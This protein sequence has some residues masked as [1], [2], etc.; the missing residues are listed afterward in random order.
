MNERRVGRGLAL[1]SLIV[2]MACRRPDRG[3]QD[4]SAS[5]VTDRA[6]ESG[7]KAA[8]S[9]TAPP[10][11]VVGQPATTTTSAYEG[12][13]ATVRVDNAGG[14]DGLL[15]S[16]DDVVDIGLVDLHAKASAAVLM[17][18]PDRAELLREMRAGGILRARS[19]TAPPWPVL[20]VFHTRRHGT[21]AAWLVGSRN[22]RIYPDR[23]SADGSV[24]WT[25]RDGELVLDDAGGWLF[26]Y[27]QGRFGP[28]RE[29]EYLAPELPPYFQLEPPSRSPP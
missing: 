18:S 26:S 28:T 2:A 23:R 9:T 13:P 15:A 11:N 6:I 17:A 8:A 1:S 22:L 4:A 16:L 5:A 20:F 10:A 24:Q 7:G 3:A 27:M 14:I 21:Y 25:S 12:G 29:K 19:L